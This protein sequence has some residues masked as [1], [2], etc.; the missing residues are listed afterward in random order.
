MENFI[1]F[2]LPIIR[3]NRLA[4]AYYILPTQNYIENTHVRSL[5]KQ[6]GAE[7]C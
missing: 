5:V 4:V 1:Q 2:E 3:L 6:A 7:L